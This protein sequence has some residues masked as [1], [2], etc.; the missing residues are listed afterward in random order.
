MQCVHR[1]TETV[2]KLN[3]KIIDERIAGHKSNA[4]AQGHSYE[5]FT[6]TAI[7][8]RIDPDVSIQD[9]DVSRRLL[10]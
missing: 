10:Q 2:P 8:Q 4:L 5:L 3:D 6:S 7:E 9:D 1:E